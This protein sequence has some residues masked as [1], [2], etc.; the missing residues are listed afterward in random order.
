M[1]FFSLIKSNLIKVFYYIN[2]V[3]HSENLHRKYYY[4]NY[5]NLGNEMSLSIFNGFDLSCQR[6]GKYWLPVRLRERPC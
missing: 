4:A 2:P 5:N 6:G 3:F 1:C